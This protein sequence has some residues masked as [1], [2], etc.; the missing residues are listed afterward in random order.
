MLYG[1]ALL[2]RHDPAGILVQ[3]VINDKK[4]IAAA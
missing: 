2:Q 4:R 1:A 3:A